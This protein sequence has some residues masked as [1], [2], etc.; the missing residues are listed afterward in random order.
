MFKIFEFMHFQYWLTEDDFSLIIVGARARLCAPQVVLWDPEVN[1]RI[2]SPMPLRRL[3][4]V[5]IGEQTQRQI[6]WLV[7]D[8]MLMS[9]PPKTATI[10]TI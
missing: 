1:S 3:E 10:K 2:N 6:N 5:T 9:A 4:P 7:V 8:L